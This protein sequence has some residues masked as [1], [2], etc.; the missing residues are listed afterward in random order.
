MKMSSPTVSTPK[1]TPYSLR[2]GIRTLAPAEVRSPLIN[3]SFFA[4]FSFF[5][6]LSEPSSAV[7]FSPF[8]SLPA[9]L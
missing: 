1:R 8:P 5:A 6:S 2:G 9:A 4:G 3:G 7:F